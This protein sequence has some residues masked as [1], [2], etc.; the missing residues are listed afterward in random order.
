MLKAAR[1]F[2]GKKYVWIGTGLTKTEAQK[3]AKQIRKNGYFA[4]VVYTP[5]AKRRKYYPR[6][7]YTLYMRQD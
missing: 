7:D 4:R 6:G 5:S 2:N 1:M 3:R